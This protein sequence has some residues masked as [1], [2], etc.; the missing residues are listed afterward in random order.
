ME[1][2]GIDIVFRVVPWRGATIQQRALAFFQQ[3]WPDG[4]V[5]SD[6][7]ESAVQLRNSTELE[8][9]SDA[10]ELF[11]Y[12]SPQAETSWTEH[13]ATDENL[14]QMIQLL[15][16]PAD[17]PGEERE[18]TVVIGGRSAELTRLVADLRSSLDAGV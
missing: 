1:I 7:T 5:E 4:V 14:D 13:G 11:F 2:G 3:R 18:V 17:E 12:P 10:P 9:L 15:V 8:S 16:A 6:E